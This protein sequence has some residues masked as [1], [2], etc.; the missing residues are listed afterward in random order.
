MAEEV[1]HGTIDTLDTGSINSV[2]VV[3]LY[4]LKCDDA[5]TAQDGQ[6]PGDNRLLHVDTTHQADDG[7]DVCHIHR[8]IV[9]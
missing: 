3:G 8:S 4:S 7:D 1:I 6:M 5:M 2:Y 9:Q